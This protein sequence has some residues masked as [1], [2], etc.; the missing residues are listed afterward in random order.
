MTNSART[1]TPWPL[2]FSAEQ[3]LRALERASRSTRLADLTGDGL[4]RE[5]ACL[6][7]AA[8]VSGQS[9]G[10]TCRLIPVADGTLAVNLPRE[11]DWG[12]IPAWLEQDIPGVAGWRELTQA[13]RERRVGPLIDQARLLGLAVARTNKPDAPTA[14]HWLSSAPIQP[15]VSRVPK[16]VDL[17]AL[18][19]GPLCSRLL[20]QCGAEVTKVESLQRPDGARFGNRR[21]FKLLNAGKRKVQLDLS[22][23][24]GRRAL[25]ELIRGADIVIEASRPRALQQMG[26]RWETFAEARPELVWISITGHGREEPQGNWVAFGDDAGVAAGLSHVMRTATGHYEFAGD[27]IADPLTGIHAALA[28]WQ[29]WCTGEGGLV[30]L[31]LRDVAAGCL[32]QELSEFGDAIVQRFADWW[33]AVRC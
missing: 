24:T 17:S 11:S 31:A 14:D 28:G 1:L 22:G 21:F 4:L 9:A 32:A 33:H 7:G 10:G 12:L 6:A 23:P 26:I 27:A 5:R 15:P 25:A 13:L 2:A 8:F 3:A 16:V 30:A 29:R 18:W 19:A 20:Q